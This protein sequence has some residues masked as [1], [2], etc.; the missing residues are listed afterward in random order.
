MPSYKTGFYSPSRRF[1]VPKYPELWYGCVGAWCPSL[2]RTG[3]ILKDM[4]GYGTDGTLTSMDAGTDWVNSGGKL[5][6][7]FDGIN[8]T[9]NIS[10]TINYG[11][12]NISF[13]GWVKKA[14]STEAGYLIAKNNDGTTSG[15]G[16]LFGSTVGSL[17]ITANTTFTT[18][19]GAYLATEWSHIFAVIMNRIIYV[20]YNGQLKDTSSTITSIGSTWPNTIPITIGNRSSA[21]TNAVIQLNALIDDLRWYNRGL[22]SKEVYTLSKSRGIAYEYI[23]KKSFLFLS[24]TPQSRKYSTLIPRIIGV[25]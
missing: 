19:S 9:I 24:S 1:G 6:L 11:S 15:P 3:Y 5:A 20:Y 17:N 21:G 4:S 7:D 22:S 13:G 14:S 10:N 12:Q 16:I 2:G 23:S 8:D 25:E 18:T